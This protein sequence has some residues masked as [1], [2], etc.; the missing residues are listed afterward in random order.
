MD[1]FDLTGEKV[2]RLRDNLGWT[3]EELSE[4]SGVA[5]RTIQNIETGVIE[6][7]GIETLKPLLKA[8]NVPRENQAIKKA[9]SILR[10]VSALSTL[11]ESKLGLIETII[12]TIPAE[13]PS[14]VVSNVKRKTPNSKR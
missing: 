8:L 1:I 13:I 2:R 6:N 3:R 11:D 10:I 4:K 5:P 12:H 14:T 9:E 7:P